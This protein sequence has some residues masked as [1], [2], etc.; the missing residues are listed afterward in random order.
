MCQECH[1]QQDE[2]ANQEDM[3][4]HPL[5]CRDGKGV[6]SRKVVEERHEDEK[7]KPIAEKL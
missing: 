6:V 4:A 1:D 5:K 2:P 7:E 3:G